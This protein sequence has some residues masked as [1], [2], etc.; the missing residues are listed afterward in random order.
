MQ[1]SILSFYTFCIIFQVTDRCVLP[2]ELHA[3]E[4]SEDKRSD[5]WLQDSHVQVYC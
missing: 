3:V 2:V 1:W 4:Q 5:P